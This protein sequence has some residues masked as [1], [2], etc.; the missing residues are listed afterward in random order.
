MQP[1]ALVGATHHEQIAV[2][3]R[4]DDVVGV[5]AGGPAVEPAAGGPRPEHERSPLA[6]HDDRD[7]CVVEPLQAAVAVE[8]LPV[9]AVP[10]EQRGH[11][12]HFTRQR[13][14]RWSSVWRSNG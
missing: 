1:I 5:F 4:E 3:G 2:S 14:V 9:V 12:S 6:E 10:I 7:Q 11:P 8:P 13:D